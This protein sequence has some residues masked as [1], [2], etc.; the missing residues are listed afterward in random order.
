MPVQQAEA[1][2]R[3]C[4]EKECQWRRNCQQTGELR[5]EMGELGYKL[6]GEC[7]ADYTDA[8]ATSGAGVFIL[9]AVGSLRKV[10][11]RGAM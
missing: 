10:F 2:Q 7:R 6:G 5:A 4:G 3:P 8:S 9:R 11:S 1:V